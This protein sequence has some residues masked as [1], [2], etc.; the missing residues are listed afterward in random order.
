MKRPIVL[1][2]FL[3]LVLTACG[4]KGPLEHPRPPQKQSQSST[5]TNER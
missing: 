3:S 2:L 5:Q 4:I 1:V